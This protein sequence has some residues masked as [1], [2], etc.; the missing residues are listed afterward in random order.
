M[1]FSLLI[2]LLFLCGGCACKGHVPHYIL[3][4]S[5]E[6]KEAMHKCQEEPDDGVLS[7]TTLE[8]QVTE[9]SQ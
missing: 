6:T 7:E 5:P 4:D 2:A 3:S 1:R 9:A 8:T